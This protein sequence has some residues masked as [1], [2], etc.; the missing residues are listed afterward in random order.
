MVSTSSNPKLGS[1]KPKC[2]IYARV[3]DEEQANKTFSSVHAQLAGGRR[4]AEDE[5]LGIIEEIADEGASGKNLNR[6]GMKRLI[7]I[8]KT[9]QISVLIATRLDRLSRDAVHTEYLIQL[10]S[11]RGTKIQLLQ[12]T[13]DEETASGRLGRR[14]NSVVSQYE[15]EAIG[16]RVR[17]KNVELAR[18]GMRAGGWTPPGYVRVKEHHYV[19]DEK[20]APMVKQIF[21]EAA[22][23]RRI[24]DIAIGLKS[25]GILVPKRE[26]HRRSGPVTIGG[27]P[28]T[29]N[30][31]K[32][33]IRNPIYKGV[34]VAGKERVEFPSNLPRIVSDEL[35]ERANSVSSRRA[36]LKYSPNQNKH[37]LLL[38]GLVVCGC[39]K[40]LLLAHPAV[41]RQKKVYLYYRCQNLRK[42]GRSVRCSVRQVPA[43]ALEAAVIEHISFLA[44]DPVV[45]EA[46]MSEAV[47]AKKAR[48]TPIK[49]EISAFD[50]SIRTLKM[51][52]AALR[53]RRLSLQ[54]GSA[55]IEEIEIEAKDLACQRRDLEAKREL[56]LGQKGVLEQELGDG[57]QL[58]ADLKRFA[59]V[60]EVL[61]PA[62]KQQA[63]R[64]IIR[65][66]VVNRLPPG[67]TKSTGEFGEN[68]PSIQKARYSIN[69]DLYVK[70][71]FSNALGKEAGIF[72]FRSE[73][74]ARAGIEPATK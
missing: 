3:S 38:N 58:K 66:I 52:F 47:S 51:R 7:S 23:G 32:H 59:D 25:S 2:L 42:N 4:M 65:R 21:E 6:P 5:S 11:E 56:L 28:F 69:L 44:R 1:E 72:V 10:C 12:Q 26:I 54:V 22:S 19:E 57:H 50:E 63:L 34:L 9:E 31:V 30:Q 73:M 40:G 62:K 55:F 45:L 39:C 68:D 13:L 46:A 60:F 18:K 49:G 35:W 53:D 16:D 48:L 71:R 14:M 64:L 41:S 43:R 61:P 37:E 36:R 29:W 70:P 74:A 8:L 67:V 20:Y 33:I 24:V 27:K 15:R 17:Y